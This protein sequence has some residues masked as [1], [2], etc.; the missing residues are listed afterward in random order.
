MFSPT[1][2]T[3]TTIARLLDTEL[4]ASLLRTHP[5]DICSLPV[6]E[7]WQSWWSWAS[8]PSS[9]PRWIDLVQY[10]TAD[11]DDDE[12]PR[13]DIP[14]DLRTLLDN[15][16]RL[17]LPRNPLAFAP[18]SLD[19][20]SL[21]GM[22]PKKAHEVSRMAA[23]VA[24]LRSTNPRLHCVQHVVDVGAGQVRNNP[25]VS[26]LPKCCLHHPVGPPFPRPEHPS[27]SPRPCPRLERCPDPGCS[28]MGSQSKTATSATPCIGYNPHWVPDPQNHSHHRGDPSRCDR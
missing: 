24:Q 16:R 14:D 2:T 11:D 26:S 6:P 17:Q 18:L 22:S 27:R 28:A 21:A 1:T 8:C 25:R 10:Y 19:H 4:V 5:N 23:Y 3:T 9:R 12:R 7:S 20:T 15:I 13:L